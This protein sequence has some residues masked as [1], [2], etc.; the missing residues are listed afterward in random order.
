MVILAT[1]LA[2]SPAVHA[3][4]RAAVLARPERPAT[5]HPASQFALDVSATTTLPL[6]VGGTIGLEVPGHL[7]FRVGAGI[8]PSA[9]VDALNSVAVGYGAYDAGDAQ[10]ASLL[11][12]DATFLEFGLGF[13]PAG[14]PGIE[15]AVSYAVLWSHRRIDM[16]QVGGAPHDAGL[17]VTVDAIHAEL[18]WQ[19]EPVEHVYFRIALGWAHAFDHHVSL[20]SSGD[21]RTQA[22][23][24]SSAD[25]LTETVGRY[26]FGPTLS[27]SLG[28]RF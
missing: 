26:A 7:V 23:M 24:R 19:S 5:A 9:Y 2:C 13:R 12:N 21:D 11:L 25:A 1:C 17:D 27:A 20:A 14:T 18:A 8:V 16:E 22:A 15:L 28:A 10:V 3:Q 4:D 6:V